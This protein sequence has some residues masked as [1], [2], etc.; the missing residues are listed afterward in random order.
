MFI[1]LVTH[2]IVAVQ[3]RVKDMVYQW[4]TVLDR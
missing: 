4:I 3:L 2:Q 1:R